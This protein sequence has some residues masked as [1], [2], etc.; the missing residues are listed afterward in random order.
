MRSLVRWLCQRILPRI[1]YPV[2]RGPLRGMRFILGAAAGSGGGASV[3]VNMVEPQ[4]TECLVRILKPGQVVFDVGANIGYY[5]LLASRLTGQTGKVL[6]FEPSPRNV[7][8]LYRHLALNRIRNA[9]VLPAACS[10]HTGLSSFSEGADCATGRL[11]ERDARSAESGLAVIAT[12]SIDDVVRES[13]LVPDVI[14]IDVEGAEEHVLRGAYQSIS[15]ALPVLLVAMHSAS[16]RLSCTDY[17]VTLGYE[18][19]AVCE[20]APGDVELLFEPSA[21][22][23]SAKHPAG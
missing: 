18:V 3:Y 4:K 20:D 5:T 10:D 6:A 19:T 16:L 12:V 9:A 7:S 11:W 13:G 2:V 8:Y 14:K 21:T 17:L 23:D 1:S 22:P 15:R